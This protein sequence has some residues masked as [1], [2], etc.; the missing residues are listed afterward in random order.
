MNGK[1]DHG[2]AWLQRV[3]WPQTALVLGLAAI[4]AAV[5]MYGPEEVRVP[6]AT[7]AVALVGLMRGVLRGPPRGGAALFALLALSLASSGCGASALRT[8]ARVYAAAAVALDTSR[9]AIRLTCTEMRDACSDALCLERALATCETAADAQDSARDAVD[10]YDRIIRAAELAGGDADV[11][12]S[13]IAA[14][15]IAARAWVA[16]GRALGALS[17]EIPM[18]GA[19]S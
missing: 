16:L 13:V 5:V 4:V 17:I 14:A 19:S 7:A 6:L 8:H 12:R 15:D 18:L 9:A 1:N 11:L 2:A 3:D 10:L